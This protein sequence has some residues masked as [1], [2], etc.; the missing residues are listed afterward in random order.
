MDKKGRPVPPPPDAL[1]TASYRLLR[2]LVR[3]LIRAGVTFPVLTDMLR[4]LYVDVAL[5]DL[6]AGPRARTDS[7]V[8]LVTGVNRKEI[9]RLRELPP[10]ADR[11]PEAVNI[12]SLAIARWRSLPAYTA[13]D[14][15]PLP[16]P[17]A[18]RVESGVT[19]DSLVESVTTDVR[20]RALLD[21]WVA[22]GLVTLDSA[23]RVHLNAA[24]F[25]PTRGRAEQMFYFARNLRDHIAAAAANVS[26]PGVAPFIDRSVHYDQLDDTTAGTLE[27]IAREAAKRVIAEVTRAGI[28]LTDGQTP[29]PAAPPRGRVNFGVYVYR[30]DGEEDEAQAGAQGETRR[31]EA[32]AS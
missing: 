21:D 28:E 20:P 18:G 26:A 12:S 30:D 17:R 27:Y 14:G 2:P 4:R 11:I 19:F 23:D 25:V 10:D 1:L 16:L 3:L 22:Q 6:P 24:S 5:A 8:S 9:R 7:R 15:A 32:P 31:P 13:P 29:A